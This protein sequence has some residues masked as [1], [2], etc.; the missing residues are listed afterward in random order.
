MPTQQEIFDKVMRHLLTQGERSVDRE[1]HCAYRGDNGKKCAIGCLIS[2]DAYNPDIEG[3]GISSLE[4]KAALRYSG[5]DY[6]ASL[7]RTDTKAELLSSLRRMHDLILPR[8]WPTMGRKLAR[9]YN[10]SPAVIDNLEE[11]KP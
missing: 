9:A 5:Y 7:S 10:L 8:E 1:G 11:A 6:L 3:R 2:D 4:V